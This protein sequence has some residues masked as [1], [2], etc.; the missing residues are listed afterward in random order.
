VRHLA[1][2]PTNDQIV[3]A[4]QELDDRHG[5]VYRT[6]NG[7]KT[8]TQV[9]S[10]PTGQVWQIQVSPLDPHT[11]VVIS[12]GALYR[13]R[14][15]GASGTWQQVSLPQITAVGSVVLRTIALSPHQ[16]DVYVIGTQTHGLWYSADAGQNWVNTDLTG[17]FEQHRS[18]TDKTPIDVKIAT[19]NNPAAAIRRDITTIAFDPVQPDTI[20]A[21]GSQRPRASFGVVRITAAGTRWERLPLQGLSHRNIYD[22]AVDA[23]GANLYAATNDGTFGLR[24]K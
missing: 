21:A 12:T 15:G 9:F 3:F 14:Q 24:L 6:I 8:W 10:S 18:M 19:A 4:V 20:Y 22:L 5:K 11:V 7:G 2:D 23:S 16:K 1:I 13:S 17:F